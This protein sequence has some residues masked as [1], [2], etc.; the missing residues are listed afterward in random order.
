MTNDKDQEDRADTEKTERYQR[1]LQI[2]T[3]TL[4]AG[5][6]SDE[7]WMDRRAKVH[8]AIEIAECIIRETEREDAPQ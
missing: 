5:Q 6:K 8:L 3:A 1:H 7:L 2:M 4:L